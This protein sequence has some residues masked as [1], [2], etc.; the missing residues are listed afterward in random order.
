M[1]CG[2]GGLFYNERPVYKEVP[3]EKQNCTNNEDPLEI[4]KLRFVNGQINVDE[5]NR[6]KQII[7]G[8]DIGLEPPE[9]NTVRNKKEAVQIQENIQRPRVSLKKAQA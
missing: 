2:F 4:L 7:L 9:K 3:R 8:T 5:Y 1:G 6:M